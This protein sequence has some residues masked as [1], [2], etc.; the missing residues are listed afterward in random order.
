MTV[1]ELCS[2][3]ENWAPFTSVSER[4]KW[5]RYDKSIVKDAECFKKANAVKL[6]SA[7]VYGTT[8]VE[9]EEV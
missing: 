4:D 5:R 1:I 2:T 3:F 8:A 6:V 7:S 9:K